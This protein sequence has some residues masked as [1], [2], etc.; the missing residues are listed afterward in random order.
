MNM[1]E[2]TIRRPNAY[3][4]SMDC[5]SNAAIK[6]AVFNAGHAVRYLYRFKTVAI[7]KCIV[8]Y[9]CSSYRYYTMSIL[10]YVKL[11]HNL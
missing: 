1:A 3:G 7:H 4:I 5:K 10:I 8:P 2:Q 6:C 11:C 9:F